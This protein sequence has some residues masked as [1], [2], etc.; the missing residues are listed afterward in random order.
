MALPTTNLTVHVDA[1]TTAQ[2]FKTFVSGGPHTG[3]PVDGDSV[4]VWASVEG[5]DRIFKQTG[6]AAVPVWRATTPLMPRP[7]LEFTGTQQ[8]VLTNNVGTGRPGSEL[9]TASAQ[10]LLI[11]FYV[12]VI[13]A[14]G[15]S[16]VSDPLIGDNSG[17]WGAMLGGTNVGGYNYDGSQDYATK[18]VTV[19][20][21]HVLMVRHQGGTLYASLDGGAES[22][23]A[24]GNTQVLTA[25]VAVGRTAQ[26]SYNFTG[27]LGEIAIY[28]TALTG[29]DL[30]DAVTY[31]TAKWLVYAPA[32][33]ATA[34]PYVWGPL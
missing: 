7:C 21:P 23:T 20:A 30:T 5:A 3:T 6:A 17:Y 16:Y 28:N 15:L 22:S 27:R 24:S 32:G 26:S 31:F 13:N 25:S 29:T 33:G 10:T 34:Q 2:L 12:S 18:S 4:M 14:S 8:L 1:S 19:G 11:A 9:I